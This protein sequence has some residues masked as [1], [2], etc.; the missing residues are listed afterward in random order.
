MMKNGLLTHACSGDGVKE[1]NHGNSA[2]LLPEVQHG[3]TVVFFFLLQRNIRIA[4][5]QVPLSG[6]A[7]LSGAMR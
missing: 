6:V 3:E 7:A 1:P 5:M 2:P 4:W